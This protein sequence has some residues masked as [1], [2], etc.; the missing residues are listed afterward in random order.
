MARLLFAGPFLDG[1]EGLSEAAEAEVWAKLEL[2]EAFPGVGSSLIEPML[3][4]AFG[5]NCLKVAAAGYDVIY[6]R[7]GD[8]RDGGGGEEELV[9]F[10]GL[11]VQRRVR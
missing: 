11:V 4:R 3:L 2:V 5:P 8:E 10:L 1:M 7:D 6:E 9:R